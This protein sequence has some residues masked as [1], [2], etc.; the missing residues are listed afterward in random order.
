VLYPIPGLGKERSARISTFIDS[1]LIRNSLE[2]GTDS[3]IKFS[4]G[5][6]I[7]FV[8]PFG[9]IQL[10]VAKP[11]NAAPTDITQIFQFTMGS[12]F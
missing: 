12:Q 1:G 10:S 4:A 9:P 8:S 11:L 7:Y 6:G 2:S 3:G 5:V